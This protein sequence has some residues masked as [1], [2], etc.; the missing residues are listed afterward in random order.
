MLSIDTNILLYASSEKSSYH[1]EACDYLTTLEDNRE[2]II[3][4]LAL[5]ELY[6]LLRNPILLSPPLTAQEAVDVCS[7]F[8]SHPRWRLVENAD[9]MNS[10]WKEASR[11]HFAR[12]RIFDL[13]LAKTLQAHGVTEFA[14]ANVK[15]FQDLGFRKVWN[16][17]LS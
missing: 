1:E 12:R 16:P 10:V 6:I 7:A 5:V 11:H 2:V 3:A 14:T 8:R 4:E 9:I 13:R 15:D 17:L